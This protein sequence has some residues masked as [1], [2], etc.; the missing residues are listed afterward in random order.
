MRRV[1]IKTYGC[2]MNERDSE[3]I[4][5]FLQASGFDMVDNETSA[6]V[7]I[8]NT[9]SVRELA[10]L[11][12][13]GKLGYLARRNIVL[14]VLGCMAKNLAEEIKKRVPGVDIILGPGDYSKIGDYIE[15]IIS[16]RRTFIIDVDSPGAENNLDMDSMHNVTQRQSSAF[17]S[18]MSG[19]NMRCSYCIVPKTRG[20]ERYRAMED[21]ILEIN[22]LA[23]NGIK[24]VTLLG[25]IVNRYGFRQIEQKDGK[26]AFVQLLEKIHEVPGI[27]R[28]RFTSPHPVGFH[29]DLIDCYKNLPKLCSQVH[30]PAQSGS[31]RILKAMR[32]AYNRDDF[33]KI[34][35][36]LRD[37]V[38]S[39][40]VSTDLIVGFPGENDDDFSETCSLFDEARFDMAFIFKYSDRRGTVAASM[41][42][43]VPR[44]VK[45]YRNAVLLKK[46][47]THSKAY[48]DKMLNT[49]QMVLVEGKARRGENI[50]QG[51][52]NNHRKVLFPGDDLDV[53]EF[54]DV[55]ITSSAVTTLYG[56]KI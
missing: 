19:C 7:I 13:L 26:S 12:A 47:A 23:D 30:L 55:R 34:V 50:F 11:K 44:D 36:A 51:R 52:A 46:L 14:C 3:S 16:G 21:I 31:N 33:I 6:D 18:I 32:R 28:I 39:I 56:E 17:V 53:G 27:K 4:H 22:K 38:P 40:S 37:T 25:Q 35:Q 10:E 48:N 15:D 54:V 2:Q 8:L 45:E 24:E 49:L 5:S 43:Q 29:R 1:F 41:P 42:D 20:T 9:C